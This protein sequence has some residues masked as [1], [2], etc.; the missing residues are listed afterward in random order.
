MSAPECCPCCGGMVAGNT[1]ELIFVKPPYFAFRRVCSECESILTGD[2]R[3]AHDALVLAFA[4][5]VG[6]SDAP[7]VH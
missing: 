1:Y 5:Q 7:A 6:G 3:A 2:D 4:N